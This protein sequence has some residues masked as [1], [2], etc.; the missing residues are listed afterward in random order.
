MGFGNVTISDALVMWNASRFDDQGL[1]IRDG[2][3]SPH[4]NSKCPEK[5]TTILGGD[6]WPVYIKAILIC[7]VISVTVV[8]LVFKATFAFW[9]MV[10]MK[11]HQRYQEALSSNT[12]QN[13]DEQQEVSQFTLMNLHDISTCLIFMP[14]LL[15]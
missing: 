8:C 7:I 2:C 3:Y 15:H 12:E 11:K 14:H 4:C 5:F 13:A 1:E 9:L 10:L 6:V